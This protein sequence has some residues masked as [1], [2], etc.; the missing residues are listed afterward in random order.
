MII[1]DRLTWLEKSRFLIITHSPFDAGPAQEFVAFL[2]DKVSLLAFINHPFFYAEEKHSSA[3]LYQKGKIVKRLVAPRIGGPDIF[4]YFKDFFFTVFFTL[5]L[6]KR[7][8]FCMAA[9]NLNTFSALVLRRLGIV[10]KVIYS[11]VD[12]TPRRFENSLLNSIYHLVDK[13]CCYRADLIWN[14]SELMVAEREKM[15]VRTEKAA[16]QITVPDGSHFEQIERPPIEKIDRFRVIFMGHLLENK[17][18][19]IL[20]EAFVEVCRKVKKA[21]LVII[22]GGVLRKRLEK[23]VKEL[24]LSGRVFFTGYIESHAELERI[25]AKGAVA[26]APY[27]PDSDSYSFYSDVGKVKV[28]L[29]CGLPVV[30]TPVPQIAYEIQKKKAGLLVDYDKKAIAEA[31]IRL[32]T[33]DRLYQK[34][35]V[36]AIKLVANYTWDNV[37]QEALMKTWSNIR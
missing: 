31:I 21:R 17:G 10:K 22:G 9:D 11:T 34:T 32:L 37:F 35:R 20:I 5:R 28:Y 33:D 4:Y 24:G 12:Y 2:K 29:A 13:I 26:V 25:M 23:R 3:T 16:K 7:F 27:V 6:G 14:S 36:N 8:D 18:I 15:G 1:K 30:I 19:M